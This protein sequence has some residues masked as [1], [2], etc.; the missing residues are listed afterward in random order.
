MSSTI[1]ERVVELKFDNKDFEQNVKVSM[2]TLDYLKSKLDTLDGTKAG[3]EEISKSLKG[4]NF[5]GV[6]NNVE[7]ISSRFS[8][9]GII[10]MTALQNITTSVMNLGK[11]MLS[12]LISPLN[13][14]KSGGMTRALNIEQAR[15]QL[16]GLQLDVDAVMAN[17]SDAVQGTAYG[18]DEAAKIAAQFGA[19]GLKAGDQMRNGLLAVA[20]AAAM[21][22]SSFGEIGQI[23]ATI[24][25]QG[26][27]MTMQL[28]QFESRGLNAAA[29]M[30]KQ[31]NTTE[32]AV[33]E[34]VHNGEINFEQFSDMMYKAFGEHAKEAND[35]FEGSLSNMRAAMSRIGADFAGPYLEH[36]RQGLHTVTEIYDAIRKTVTKPIAEGPYKRFME[37]LE[38]SFYYFS[39][40]KGPQHLAD[41][42]KLVAE[43]I[44]SIVKPIS[45]AWEEIFPTKLWLTAWELVNKFGDFTK[46]FKL[47]GEAAKNLKDTF[48]GLFSI[49]KLFGTIIK[50][51]LN[52]LIPFG[53]PLNTL[54][55]TILRI[56]GFIGRLITAETEW[57]TK[58]NYIGKGLKVIA[59][60]LASVVNVLFLGV[61]A[62]IQFVTSFGQMPVVLN[63]L[64][65]IVTIF[66]KIGQF[67]SPV[68]SKIAEGID[69]IVM[70][71]QELWAMSP[72]E[73]ASHVNDKLYEMRINFDSLVKS[74]KEFIGNVRDLGINQAITIALDKAGLSA[75]NFK[76]KIDEMTDGTILE[77]LTA[78]LE[79][80]KSKLK[81]IMLSFGETGAMIL[82]FAKKYITPSNLIIGG[83]TISLIYLIF[84]MGLLAKSIGR[85]ADRARTFSLK[86][87][88][89]IGVRNSY[90]NYRDIAI[91]IALIAGSLVALAN[92]PYDKLKQAAFILGI[93]AASLAGF[94]IVI[95]LLNK[96]PAKSG[97][98]IPTMTTLLIS[99][100]G[101]VAML[102]MALKTLNE[103]DLGED[104]KKKLAIIAAMAV[105]MGA[106]AIVISK[107]A[108]SLSTGSIFFVSFAASLYLLVKVFK[109][110]NE[111]DLQK[112]SDN[113]KPLTMI[114]VGF[115]VM[116]RLAGGMSLSSALGIILLALAL[117]KIYDTFVE[118]LNDS[119][120]K[121]VQNCIASHLVLF[122]DIIKWYG[123]LFPSHLVAQKYPPQKMLP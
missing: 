108:P 14:I 107:V 30:A 99:L 22:G 42:L 43:T 91:S 52:A 70:H 92:V 116:C 113:I 58:N 34:M 106:L 117:K 68:T 80:L 104:Y 96:I 18:L 53:D 62:V 19:S 21:T 9:L 76:N 4:M 54:G 6:A 1:D 67:L 78:G 95:N 98:G 123:G 77:G 118:V 114:L 103:I 89:G 120:F 60:A 65:A 41:G 50:S 11:T 13:Q 90:Q 28:R 8:T 20:G 61:D 23:F 110:L 75:E 32:D 111:A 59:T 74:I 83:F 72:V 84:R 46:H 94:I 39:I 101:S 86:S 57:I 100:A 45:K 97:S 38:K 12:K 55:G 15:F 93:F 119:N 73:F 24:A 79:N 37:Q 17:V 26:K 5:N 10:G 87:L 102:V 7:G 2:N 63:I 51:I 109:E 69:N 115:G 48:K 29:A 71:I 31:M 27:V 47:T 66:Q 56:T 82:D 49:L 88:L 122:Q 35:T 105:G 40:N 25:G 33:R 85:L 36:M 112:L 121:K 16:K 81:S 3:V 64:D 44:M